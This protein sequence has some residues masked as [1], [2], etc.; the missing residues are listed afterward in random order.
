MRDEGARLPASEADSVAAVCPPFDPPPPAELEDP[1]SPDPSPDAPLLLFAVPLSP[2]PVDP[3]AV[4]PLPVEPL[5]VEPLTEDPLTVDPLVVD[6]LVVDP[7]PVDPL[8]VEPL[9]AEPLPLFDWEVPDVGSLVAGGV[10]AGDEGEAGDV[11]C[12]GGDDDPVVGCGCAE[13]G[14]VCPPAALPEEGGVQVGAD[15]GSSAI[16]G[17]SGTVAPGLGD[18]TVVMS[19]WVVEVGVDAVAPPPVPAEPLAL[20]AVVVLPVPAAPPVP[21]VLPVPVAPLAPPALPVPAALPVPFAWEPGVSD[22][23]EGWHL[24][25]RPVPET[26]VELPVVDEI[27]GMPERGVPAGPIGEA[28]LASVE[29]DGWPPASTLELTC[30]SACRNG[31]TASMAA[32]ANATPAVATRSRW[33]GLSLRGKESRRKE[34]SCQV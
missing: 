27:P 22:T 21:V 29:P 16:I 31:V 2:S 5:P 17:R 15:A 24:A 34:R 12:D 25:S 10:V 3:L 14:G 28:P 23:D 8:A 13:A 11:G 4:D 32:M 26:V 33:T 6:P 20:G 18:T 1:L 7:S 30:T 19:G 9:A